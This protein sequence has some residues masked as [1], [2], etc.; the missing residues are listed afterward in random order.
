MYWRQFLLVVM[1]TSSAV[2]KSVRERLPGEITPIIAEQSF[3][4]NG[5]G[6]RNAIDLDLHT[7]SQT[8]D[9]GS[10][11]P[12][13]LKLKLPNL[14]CIDEVV[15]FNSD[16]SR[17]YTWTCTDSDCSHCVGEDCRLF[18]L[19]VRIEG[20]VPGNLDSYSDCKY[21]DTVV[22]QLLSDVYIM[23]VFEIALVGKVPASV[24]VKKNRDV[25]DFL[26]F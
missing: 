7:Q 12:I 19:E 25:Q 13:W 3:I 23:A 2:A 10:G 22:L 16:G 18:S 6:P 1:T 8:Y 9:H 4:Y 21:G 24:T 17:Q 26:W 5:H 14:E 11:N 20:E 15:E